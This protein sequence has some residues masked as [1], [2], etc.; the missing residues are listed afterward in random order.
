[1][2]SG[3]WAGK[4]WC[5]PGLRMCLPPPEGCWPQEVVRNL[6]ISPVP[7]I[8]TNSR[9]LSGSHVLAKLP[10]VFP[11][12]LD[13]VWLGVLVA[14]A[15]SKSVWVVLSMEKKF[16]PPS[17]RLRQGGICLIFV[18]RCARGFKKVG[19]GR[20]QW[21]S[22]GWSG[23]SHRPGVA[24]AGSAHNAGP[25]TPDPLSDRNHC[26]AHIRKQWKHTSF[27]QCRTIGLYPVITPTCSK[28]FLLEL[29]LSFWV[30]KYWQ[31]HFSICR[32]FKNEILKQ[33]LV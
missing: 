14:G 12:F 19:G 26:P 5:G 30:Q 23:S 13:K 10:G 31:G 28:V 21:A 22:S 2:E 8:L 11:R 3:K 24:R 32:S 27:P 1:M 18:E 20:L 33:M 6:P 29:Y 17:V 9:K 7:T 16:F 25:A 15:L 4:Q